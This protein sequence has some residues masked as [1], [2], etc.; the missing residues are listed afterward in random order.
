MKVITA[1]KNYIKTDKEIVLQCDREDTAISFVDKKKDFY[2]V[3][4][5]RI[6]NSKVKRIDEDE[7]PDVVTIYL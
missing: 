5:E 6:A 4:G 3:Y 1:V 7:S 2:L